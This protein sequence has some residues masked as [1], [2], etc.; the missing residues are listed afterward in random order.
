MNTRAIANR[1]RK[2]RGSDASHSGRLT[3][4]GSAPNLFGMEIT[5]LLHDCSLDRETGCAANCVE[6][7][8]EN[9]QGET[10]EECTADLRSAVK[11][12]LEYRRESALNSLSEGERIE[13][14]TA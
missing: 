2:A 13:V 1:R 12:L 11:D 8:E 9:G 3:S 4:S 7:P 5:A 10:V 6:F 14:V